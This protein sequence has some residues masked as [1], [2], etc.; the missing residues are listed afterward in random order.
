MGILFGDTVKMLTKR[1]VFDVGSGTVGLTLLPYA[2]QLLT[3]PRIVSGNNN[4]NRL[5]QNSKR[6]YKYHVFHLIWENQYFIFVNI[7]PIV[8]KCYLFV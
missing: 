2:P 8:I 7:C 4:A 5:S 1:P 3:N 6:V